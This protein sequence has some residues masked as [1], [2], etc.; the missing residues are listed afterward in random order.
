MLGLFAIPQRKNWHDGALVRA[1]I[2]D[3][4]E[5]YMILIRRHQDFTNAVGVKLT[6][7]RAAG[8]DLAILTL[9]AVWV[10]RKTIPREFTYK[11]ARFEFY[12]FRLIKVYYRQNSG[13]D[14]DT[15]NQ[16]G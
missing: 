8:I 2:K 13:Y 14:Y 5:A 3:D 12:L 16:R 7:D 11:K 4:F 15:D 6:G 10:H 9:M 1:V